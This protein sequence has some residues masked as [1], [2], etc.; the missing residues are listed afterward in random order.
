[1]PEEPTIVIF[2]KWKSS[3]HIS[4]L[5][6]IIALF[7]ELPADIGA[8]CASFEH[9]GQHG[10]ADY[11]SVIR[12]TVPATPEEYADLKAE[13]EGPNYGYILTILKRAHWKH[14]LARQTALDKY[15]RQA[16]SEP[17]PQLGA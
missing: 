12:R 15:R 4:G 8:S 7:P 3:E 1:M 6:D 2:R 16:H 17:S 9:F 10:A 13:L 11:N 14:H 5:G